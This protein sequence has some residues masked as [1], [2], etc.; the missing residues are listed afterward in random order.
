[1]IRNLRTAACATAI[2]SLSLACGQQPPDTGEATAAYDELSAAYDAAETAGDWVPQ[3][4]AFLE[5]YPNSEQAP[6]VASQVLY[7]RGEE[8]GDPAGAYAVVSKLLD[9]VDDPARR[10]EIGMELAPI[11]RKVGQPVDLAAFVTALEA[12]R[13]L[14]FSEHKDVMDQAAADG[15]WVLLGQQA[16]A[17]LEQASADAYRADYPDRELADARVQRAVASR[18]GEAL[19]AEAW[20][21]YNLGRPDEAFDLFSQAD[22]AMPRSYL[23]VP[24][25]PLPLYR[26]RALIRSGKADEALDVLAPAA[27]FG[28]DQTDAMDLLRAAW[29]GTGRQ[30]EL[31]D[32]WIDNAR[33]RLAHTVDDVRL[34]SYNGELHSLD[35]LRKD[36]VMLLA[37]WFPT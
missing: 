13:P 37:F 20:A 25:G 4:E 23:G 32:G 2:I 16:A 21:A 33:K 3:A 19:A 31:L 6:E 27:L 7:Y 15:A 30:P 5:A 36:K 9:R 17:G 26:G 1:V 12:Q 10:F 8:M 24:T 35:D 11:A 28:E 22:A 18:R 34:A 29:A 14:T